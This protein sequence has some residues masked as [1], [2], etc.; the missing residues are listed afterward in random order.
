MTKLANLARLRRA[1]PAPASL[2]APPGRCAPHL[3]RASPEKRNTS[4]SLM[5][6]VIR[7]LRRLTPRKGTT[8]RARIY[9][10]IAATIAPDFR[11]AG[12]PGRLDCHDHVERGAGL[13]APVRGAP[14][15]A[16]SGQT[17]G[18]SLNSPKTLPENP[19]GTDR[20]GRVH[21]TTVRER[22]ARS[23]F[24]IIEDGS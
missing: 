11:F 18:N 15:Q 12:R 14:D 2:R 24:W 7:R 21:H 9:R 8:R 13:A 4:I 3:K 6:P 20:F 19:S 5:P 22:A 16:R 23:T 17:P 10:R 1:Q